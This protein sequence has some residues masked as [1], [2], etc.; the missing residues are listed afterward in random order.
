MEKQVQAWHVT[1]R[2]VVE[3]VAFSAVAAP[4]VAM[5]QESPA[6]AVPASTVTTPPR[7]F[8]PNAPR[9]P[10]RDPDVITVDPAFNSLVLFNGTIRRL[11]T[12]GLY[13]EGPAWSGQGRYLVWGDPPANR[14]YRWLDD[15]GHV[16]VFRQPSSHS[17]GNT[18]DFQGRQVS[19]ENLARRVVRY[20][21]DG[22]ASVLADSFEGK[23]LNS[24]NDVVAHPD[25]SYWFTDP[26]YGRSLYSGAP[27]EPGGPANRAGNFKPTLGQA[28][29]F[30]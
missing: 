18:F 28:P 14:Q 1:R 26:P 10:H 24:P 29:G 27:D 4:V 13:G 2:R 9:A 15:D 22:S 23:R 12:G 21:F 8:G 17:N 19:C 20:E 25:G 11:W 5:A 3:A 16:S 7:D 6:P 30:L